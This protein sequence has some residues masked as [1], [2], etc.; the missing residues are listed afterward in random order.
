MKVEQSNYQPLP[1]LDARGE[2]NVPAHAKGRSVAAVILVAL[3]VFSGTSA[4][5]LVAVTIIFHVTPILALAGGIPLGVIALIFLA[6]AACSCCAGRI[7]HRVPN[8][9]YQPYRPVVQPHSP[10]SYTDPGLS[11]RSPGPP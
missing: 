11:R 3:A 7:P 8:Q 9:P 2:N 10:F 6:A 1:P 5:V 4:A